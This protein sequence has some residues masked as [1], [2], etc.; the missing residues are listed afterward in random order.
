MQ[1]AVPP[2]APLRGCCMPCEGVRVLIVED[3][4]F[5]CDYDCA[6]GALR[7]K[8]WQ[9][10]KKYFVSIK[11]VCTFAPAFERESVSKT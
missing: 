8:M 4:V 6:E 2:P 9:K 10:N 3:E 7:Q 1:A 5:E 11:I